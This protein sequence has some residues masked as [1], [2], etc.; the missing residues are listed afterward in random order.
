[1]SDNQTDKIKDLENE[2]KELLKMRDDYERNKVEVDTY[3]DTAKNLGRENDD[4]NK[5]ISDL[6]FKVQDLQK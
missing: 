6:E 2:N 4:L 1:M 5:K 3:R